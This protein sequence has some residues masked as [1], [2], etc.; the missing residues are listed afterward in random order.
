[1]KFPK[2]L[3]SKL[4]THVLVVFVFIV[5]SIT[6]FSPVLQGKKIYQSDI[7]QYTGMSKEQTDFRNATNQEPYWTNSAFG[8]MPT[9]QLGAQYPHNYIKKL[10]KTIRFLPRPADYLFLY[11]IGFYILLL[12]LKV[13]YKLA[14]LGALAFGFSTY[15]II[16]LGVGHNAKAHAIGYFPMVLAGI[17]LTFQKK[18]IWGFLLT[19]FA[20][21]LEINANHFQMTY[22]LLLLILVFGFV[23]LYDAFKTKTLPHFF[24]SVSILVVSVLLAITTNATNLLATQEYATWSTRGKSELTINVDGSQKEQSGL[25]KDYI[26]EYSYGIVESLNLFIPRLFGGSNNENI[27]EKSKTYEFLVNQGVSRSDAKNFTSGL[28][29]YWGTQPIVA[30]PA[31]VGAVVLF[32][33]VLALFLVKNRLKWWLVGGIIV[34]L[35]LSWGK[36]FSFLTDFM[37]ANVPLYN[38]FRAVSSIQVILELC[39]PILATLGLVQFFAKTNLPKKKEKALLLTT[40][41][42]AGV[43]VLLLLFK[44]TF[45]FVGASDGLYR[46][47]YGNEVVEMIKLDRKALFNA[48]VF[49]TLIYVLLAGG[50]LWLFAKNRLKRSWGI[51]LIGILLVADL[52]SV[53]YRYVNTDDFVLAR[54][55][56]QTFIASE[57]DREILKDTAHYRVFEPAL[58]LSGAR[59]SYFHQAVG[60]YHA[61]KPRRFQELYDFYIAKNNFSVLHLLNVKYIIQQNE[62]GENYVVE[63]PYANGNAWFA[64]TLKIVKNADDEIRAL[65]SLDVKNEIVLNKNDVPKSILSKEFTLDSTAV[66]NLISYKPNHLVYKSSATKPQLAVFSEMYYPKGWNVYIDGE[67]T[68]HFR[69]NYVLRAMKIPSGN[70]KIEFIFE[71]E[72]IKTGSKIALASSILLALCLLGG[73]WYDFNNT[74]NQRA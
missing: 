21:A 31:Y 74:K 49:R 20:M 45:D 58:G 68:S 54:R 15:L 36:N 12:V 8:G 14:I 9:Y 32:L 43:C 6:Y 37:I 67:K 22:Y 52:V 28:P 48:D 3:F 7:V 50:V 61:A 26:T 46:Q 25:S 34:S 73:L 69:S 41:I 24:T 59:T 40:G 72:V 47:Y 70:H 56:K 38:K 33:F 1:M 64:S 19:A 71:P 30:A 60:G 16:I 23:Y 42:T 62:T 55:L 4:F 66:I 57:V 29:T 10:D 27:G 44:G 53:N 63:N 18:Y 51:A 5:A 39:I 17:L 11:F 65:D 2:P 35:L 13:D